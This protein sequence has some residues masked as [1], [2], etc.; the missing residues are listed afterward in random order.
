MKH[1]HKRDSRSTLHL[2]WIILG[3]ALV[4]VGT[5]PLLLPRTNPAVQEPFRGPARVA[6]ILE[7]A[8]YNCHSN[9][10]EWPWYSALPP[11]A[12]LLVNHVNQ[13]REQLNFSEWPT[14][15]FELQAMYFDGIWKAVRDGTMPPPSYRLA[16]PQS[17]L[18]DADR[19]L[20]LEWFEPTS[21]LAQWELTGQ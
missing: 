8:C 12:W 15:D 20:L 18:T 1:E 11:A 7:R 16:H 6:D 9:E 14:L 10:T 3:T 17:R 5:T 21:D 13:G 4:L 19:A 2:G